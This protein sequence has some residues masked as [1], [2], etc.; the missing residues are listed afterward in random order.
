MKEAQP[1]ED[2]ASV[3]DATSGT[4]AYGPITFGEIHPQEVL[5][6]ASKQHLVFLLDVE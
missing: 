2:W 5:D 6:G 1:G 3:M 4:E